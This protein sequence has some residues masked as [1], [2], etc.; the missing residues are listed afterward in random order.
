MV[1]RAEV[2]RFGKMLKKGDRLA[3]RFKEHGWERVERV[4]T[5]L[6]DV[7][8]RAFFIL[9]DEDGKTTWM[10]TRTLLQRYTL[11]PKPGPRRQNMSG[12]MDYDAERMRQFGW[13]G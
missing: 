7:P 2:R 1:T 5:V 12:L 9:Q 6:H 4:L 13:E 3:N 8:G 11:L 10:R